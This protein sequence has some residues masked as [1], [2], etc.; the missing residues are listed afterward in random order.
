MILGDEVEEHGG[1]LFHRRVEFFASEGLV[2]L[3]DAAL[4]RVVLLVAKPLATTELVMQAT[5]FG[6]GI[7]VRGTERGF[8]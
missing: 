8:G 1:F 7:L 6:H 3:T 2:Y 5:D 4:E